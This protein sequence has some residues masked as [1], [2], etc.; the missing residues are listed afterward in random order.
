MMAIEDYFKIGIPEERY[1]DFDDV[2]DIIDLI[3]ALRKRK[4]A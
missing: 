3:A 1:A 2:G 4:P